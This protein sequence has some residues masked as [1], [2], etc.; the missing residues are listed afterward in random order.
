MCWTVL[1]SVLFFHSVG[2]CWTCVGQCWTV[3]DSVGQCWTQCLCWTN[4]STSSA[5]TSSSFFTRGQQ[6]GSMISHLES[7][8]LESSSSRVISPQP[9]LPNARR[10]RTCSN[11]SLT[12]LPPQQCLHMLPNA[13]RVRLVCSRLRKLRLVPASPPPTYRLTPKC[14]K[15]KTRPLGSTR[16]ARSHRRS[17]NCNGPAPR[18]GDKQT[19]TRVASVC[20]ASSAVKKYVHP[21]SER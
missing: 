6:H 16:Q 1:D 5:I 7:S 20:Q 4:T 8:H 14:C 15:Y 18:H 13:G 12:R 19:A 3:L 10:V 2:Q 21:H 17:T 11:A 9:M